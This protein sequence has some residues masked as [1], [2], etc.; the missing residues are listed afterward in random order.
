MKRQQL[1]L[2]LVL[3]TCYLGPSL[4]TTIARTRKSHALSSI[5][6]NYYSYNKWDFRKPYLVA[7]S[8]IENLSFDDRTEITG[9]SFDSHVLIMNFSDAH[10]ITL[11]YVLETPIEISSIEWH[12]E[13]PNVLIGGCISGQLIVWDL[14]CIESRI[15]TGKKPE[16]IK[17]PDEEEDKSKSL[18]IYN[19]LFSPVISCQA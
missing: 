15:T 2:R 9:K 8:M 6:R 7:M 4:S 3:L 10:I 18:E 5:H 14:S 1:P 19:L 13:N 11:N 12:P 16:Q 17:M